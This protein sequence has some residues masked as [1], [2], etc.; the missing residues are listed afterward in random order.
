[1][2]CLLLPA[3]RV[4]LPEPIEHVVN[5]VHRQRA[6]RVAD[7]QHHRAIVETSRDIDGAVTVGVRHGV[8]QD[9]L[10]DEPQL[11]EIGFDLP[12][13]VQVPFD[14]QAM[15]VGP[16]LQRLPAVPDEGREVD[17]F[18][19]DFEARNGRE[20]SARGE[21]VRAVIDVK[22]FSERLKKGS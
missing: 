19:P 8:I 21:H 12:Q 11:I 4:A 10:H 13:G 3:G 6:A 15:P 22:R 14:V 9:V 17:R 5:L 7:G 20:L 16:F 2:G 18:T 1:M